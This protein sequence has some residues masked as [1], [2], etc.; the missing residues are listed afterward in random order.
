[1]TCCP[2]CG[3]EFDSTD[4]SCH[5]GCPLSGKCSMVKCPRCGYEFINE[6]R[7]VDFIKSL[8]NQGQ[9]KKSEVSSDS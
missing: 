2:F 9:K 6:S 8:F 1:M 4:E 5:S 7:T 3:W